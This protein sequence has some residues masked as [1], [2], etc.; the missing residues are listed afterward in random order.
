MRVFVEAELSDAS[1]R[2]SGALEGLRVPA[3]LSRTLKITVLDRIV[4]V[5]HT[6]YVP[7]KAAYP[8]GEIP[9]CVRNQLVLNRAPSMWA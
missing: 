2:R 8:K 6:V 3:V 5:P 1:V 4:C 9:K 7:I